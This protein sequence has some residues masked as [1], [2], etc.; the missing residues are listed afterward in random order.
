M[1][2]RE[3]EAP[4]PPPA[5]KASEP[6]AS[7]AEEPSAAD[8]PE[9][10]AGNEADQ[11]IRID[12]RLGFWVSERSVLVSGVSD[13]ASARLQDALAENILHWENPCC[14]KGPMRFGGRFLATRGCRVTNLTIF[15]AFFVQPAKN[16]VPDGCFCWAF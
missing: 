5:L 10:E 12:A 1:A 2:D 11:Q 16:S 8:L 14:H 7:F 9:L 13:E 15:M 4:K 6:Q 3:A